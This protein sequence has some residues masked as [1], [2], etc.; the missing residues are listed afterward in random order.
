MLQPLSKHFHMKP[1]FDE[2][3]A[4]RWFAI[5]YNNAAWD[6]I[7]SPSPKVGEIGE[8][9]HI[10]HASYLHWSKAGGPEE[11]ARALVLLSMAY[12]CAKQGRQALEYARRSENL[13]KK[14]AEGLGAFDRTSIFL[15][16]ARSAALAAD[17][18]TAKKYRGKTEDEA[19]K[20]TDSSE[21]EV[22]KGM[23]G[24]AWGEI[25]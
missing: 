7:E 12:L 10:A 22:I 5:E 9:I 6:I 3:Q 17:L 14:E 16:M 24:E 1:P 11:K 20:L 2:V 4:H 8:L 25:E 13:L 21:R 23:K 19:A 15:V 18:E